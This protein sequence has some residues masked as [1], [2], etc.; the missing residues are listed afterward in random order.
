MNIYS[1][2]GSLEVICGPMFSGKTEELI[3][4]IKRLFYAKKKVMVFKH[5]FD[6]RY[7]SKDKIC[8]HCKET[9]EAIGIKNSIDMLGFLDN[10]IDVVCVD[11]VQFFGNDVVVNL[12]RIIRMGKRVIVAGLELDF[13][14]IP[15]G[16]M[17]YLLAMA[18]D[19]VKL[20]SICF[21]SG[22]DAFFNQR[23]I[24]GRPASS[25]DSTILVGGAEQYEARSREFFEIDDVPIEEYIRDVSK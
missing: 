14:G 22:K 18:D 9:I 8:T 13:R 11:E 21:K 17:P 1:K 5:S 3:R 2:N 20:K 24:N 19:V 10:D 25:R 16:P 6:N 7:D 15:F 4:R 23:I 12:D